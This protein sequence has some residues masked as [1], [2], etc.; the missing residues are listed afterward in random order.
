MEI[1]TPVERFWFARTDSARNTPRAMSKTEEHSSGGEHGAFGESLCGETPGRGAEG[2]AH[3]KFF[4]AAEGA[5][6]EQA[7]HVRTGDEQNETHR[8]DQDEQGSAHV[9]V[10]KFGEGHGEDA[11]AGISGIALRSGIVPDL[12]GDEF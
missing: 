5:R 6:E 7:G 1:A 3:G 2:V 4:G 12:L 8:T 10:D 11:P 9:T